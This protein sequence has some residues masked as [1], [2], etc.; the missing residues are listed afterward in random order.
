MFL[1]L[2]SGHAHPLLSGLWCLLRY[3]LVRLFGSRPHSPVF[4]CCIRGSIVSCAPGIVL[5]RFS[6]KRSSLT[7]FG[8]T[9]AICLSRC[10]G[11]CVLHRLDMYMYFGVHFSLVAF[12]WN[13]Y[14]LW[15]QTLPPSAL[16]WRLCRRK[17]SSLPCNCI[18]FA[19]FRSRT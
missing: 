8:R 14:T 9:N 4:L 12:V 2:V 5:G 16:P 3:Q 11:R 10:V 15:H 18:D 13:R 1:P 17:L 19:A 7:R 6:W